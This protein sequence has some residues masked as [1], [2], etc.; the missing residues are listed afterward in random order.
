MK[1]LYEK[2]WDL[3]DLFISQRVSKENRFN[4]QLSTDE[5]VK[6]LPNKAHVLWIPN[7]FFVG[8]FPQADYNSRNPDKHLHQSGR[9]PFSDSYVDTFIQGGGTTAGIIEKIVSPHFLGASQILEGC[10]ASLEELKQREKF[11]DIV[12]SEYIEKNYQERQLFYSKNHPA[13]EVLQKVTS[14]ILEAIDIKTVFTDIQAV[15]SKFTLKGQDV[16]L[17][18]SVVKVLGMTLF[19][20]RIGIFGHFVGIWWNLRRSI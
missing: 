15:E 4:P 12:I 8:Y 9:F 14:R 6:L 7:A 20:I 3:C 2:F 5:L 11:C 17:Y 16:P 10:W 19:F 18:P 1:W 13:N